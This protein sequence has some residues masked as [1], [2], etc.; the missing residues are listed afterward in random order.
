MGVREPLEIIGDVRGF[1]GPDDEVPVVFHEA[2]VDDAEGEF[3]RGVDHDAFESG[4]IAVAAK[5]GDA[6]CGAIE[7]VVEESRADGARVAW[8]GGH[9][10][11]S[12]DALSK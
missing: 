11:P 9:S 1:S 4:V 3:C 10:N 2:P 8:H 12:H 5:Q 6:S 7:D